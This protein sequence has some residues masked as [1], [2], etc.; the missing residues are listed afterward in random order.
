[1]TWPSA[2]P[3]RSSSSPWRGTILPTISVS[4]E[5]VC[6]SAGWSGAI[7]RAPACAPTPGTAIARGSSVTRRSR[8]SM[9]LA[10][11]A[12]PLPPRAPL[13]TRQ[14]AGQESC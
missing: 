5:T 14:G 13:G 2:R 11:L 8:A 7:G 3:G 6:A 1:L 4:P 10:A 9:L 12:L